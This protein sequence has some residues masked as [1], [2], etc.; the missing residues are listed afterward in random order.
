MRG[1]LVIS[2]AGAAAAAGNRNSGIVRGD[3]LGDR[4]VPAV[5]GVLSVLEEADDLPK[6]SGG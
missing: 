4:R 6:R 2:R 1:L 5:E 3:V